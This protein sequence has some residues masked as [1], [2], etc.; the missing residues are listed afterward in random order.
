LINQ[1]CTGFSS[2]LTTVSYAAHGELKYGAFA[3]EGRCGSPNLVGGT[4]A[5]F[6]RFGT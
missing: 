2:M 3:Y 4:P 5:A 1:R 6:P